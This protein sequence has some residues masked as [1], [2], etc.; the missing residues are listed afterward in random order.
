MISVQE[1]IIESTSYMMSRPSF[2]A[3]RIFLYHMT[4]TEPKEQRRARAAAAKI[5]TPFSSTYLLTRK[6]QS[7]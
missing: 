5:P 7:Q 2:C 1:D 6:N 4:L 3:G